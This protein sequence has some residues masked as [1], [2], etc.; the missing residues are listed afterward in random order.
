MKIL[1]VE[2][3]VKVADLVKRSLKENGYKVVVATNGAAGLKLA[4]Q[5]TFSL[6]ILDRMLPEMD[7]LTVTKKLRSA[8]NLTPI[9][10]LSACTSTDDIITGLD[11]GS[12]DYVTK[13]FTI[14]ELLVRVRALLRR[15]GKGRGAELL[16]ED[17]KLD[18][19]THKV[20][21]AGN[22]IKLTSKEYSLLEYMMRTPNAVLT[23]DM[24]SD[25]VWNN[26][27]GNA[28]NRFSNIIDV[29]INYLRKKLDNDYTVKLI[30]TAHGQGYI[31]KNN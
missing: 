27:I 20:W 25:N 2:D 8:G 10:T 21:R 12:D 17:V 6:V 14:M 31:L 18:P 1:V 9:L 24:I 13:P 30:H 3:D 19:V 15:T 29:N 23:R 26:A 11:A 4:L 16:F 28:I 22:E 5:G 7:G